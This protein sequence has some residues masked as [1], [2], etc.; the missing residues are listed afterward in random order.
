[1]PFWWTFSERLRNLIF[2][3]GLWTWPPWV[4]CTPAFNHKLK[5]YWIYRGFF[6]NC[7][8]RE[9]SQEDGINKNWTMKKLLHGKMSLRNSPTDDEWNSKRPNNS[10]LWLATNLCLF[11]PC[12][13]CAENFAF[14]L[15]RNIAL[16]YFTYLQMADTSRLRGHPLKLRK[17]RSTLNLRNFTFS[18]RV[19]N[20]WNDLPA[21]FVTASPVKAFKKKLEAHLTNLP[22]RAP[23]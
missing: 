18:Q 15:L 19:V 17:D 6:W 8:L 22:R 1:M 3:R 7:F 5:K 21:Y 12:R 20:M 2:W 11:F 9:T 16:V 14:S 10:L 13:N 4:I 23:K